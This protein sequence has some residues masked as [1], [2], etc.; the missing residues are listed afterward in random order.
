M[1]HRDG[2]AGFWFSEDAG[3]AL[4]EEPN[5]QERAACARRQREVAPFLASGGLRGA[6]PPRA[7]RVGSFLL[8]GPQERPKARLVDPGLLF[9]PERPPG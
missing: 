1:L 9:G 4:P 3:R 7:P 6:L 5:A 8:S 2:W